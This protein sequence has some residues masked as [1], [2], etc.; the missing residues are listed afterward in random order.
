MLN[1]QFKKERTLMK[2]IFLVMF[3]LSSTLVFAQ[4]KVSGIVTDKSGEPLIGVNVLEKGTTN[5]C[6]TDID[7]KYSLNVEKNKI[8]VFSFIGYTK[9]EI[10]T[11]QSTINVTLVED[12]QALEEVVI[13]GY[14]S[15]TRKDVT[16][17]ITT[18]KADKLNQGVFS[19]PGQLLQGKVPGLTITQSSDPNSGT[20]SITLRGASTLRTGAAQE[21]Y[22]IIDGVPG[23]S[24]SLIS[25]DDIESI[26]VL[27]DATATAIYGSKAA[28]GVIIVTTKKGS[29]ED[30]TN[31]SYSGYMAIDNVMK[32]LDMMS[33]SELRAYA[34]KNNIVF[35]NDMGANTDWQKEV[36]RTAFSHN[37][38]VSINGGNEKTSYSASI[39][40]LE[41]QGAIRGTNMDRLTARSFLQTKTLQNRLTLSLSLNGSVTNK[42]TTPTG[43][44]GASVLDAMNYY[45]PLVPIRDDEGN[46]YEDTAISQNYNP[47]SLINENQYNSETKFL[48]GVAKASL[49][50]V[51]GLV[52]NLSLS[53]QNEQYVNNLYETSKSLVAKGMDG[54]SMRES[55]TN[56]K[57][58]L[59]TYLNYDKT[60]N[61]IHKLGLMAGYSWEEGNDNDGFKLTTYGYYNDDLS[62]HNMGMANFIDKNGI[63]GW[64]MSTLRMISFYA[65]V[66]YSLASKYLLQATI[67]RDGS[68]A[69]G[70]NNRWATFPSA[71]LAWRMSEESFIK[72]LNIFDDLKF[73]IG[74]GVSGNSLG[75]NAYSAIQT[76]GVTGWYDYI[77]PSGSSYPVHTLGAASNSNPDLKWERTGMFNIGL[78]FAFLNNRLSGTIEWYNKTT[79]DLIYD[80]AVSTNRYPFGSMTANVGE[81]NNKGI[82]ITINAVP[83]KT[84]NF[85][86]ETTL[87]LSHNKNEVVK[88]SNSAYSVKYINQGNA[89]INGISSGAIADTQRIMEGQPIGT[90]YMLEWAGVNEE[91]QSTWYKRN[92]ET[93]ERTGEVT[94]DPKDTDRTIVGNAQPKLTYGWNNTLTWKNWSLTAFIQGTVG[95]K[96]FNSTRAQYNSTSFVTLGKNV[97]REVANC[98]AR[99][100]T[101]NYPS[102]RYL[103][104]GSYLRLSTLSLGYNFGKIGNWLNNLR[105][106][107]TCNNLFTITGYKGTDPEVSLGGIAPG[108]DSRETYY[109]RTRTFMLGLNVNF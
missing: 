96:I 58:V 18:V 59:E 104:D 43:T 78:D 100:K 94:S 88:L 84:K 13:V 24:L 77:S 12:A 36:Q 103:E 30:H 67:R 6:I 41:K 65:R 3:M 92:P 4:N 28:N 49:N 50:I 72:N 52:Y 37:H 20:S 2:G 71:S 53:Y 14:G 81:I 17:S 38:N 23:M 16:S 46:W 93:G 61:D 108:I 27:R 66:N 63:G 109:P 15:M 45:S 51:D 79:K 87:N 69:F 106:Y 56:K 76:Y 40:Y 25:P 82:E 44:D 98:D 64:E 91:G 7:G 29:K 10:P 60:F 70:K 90:F 1:V 83:V 105:V 57:K 5:G 80:Y 19:D 68:S 32:N 74:Y 42:Y 39:N 97:L 26:D 75:F 55:V 47:L 89:N 34:Q 54:R 21:P 86:W 62:Y 22:Y 31:V 95:N 35:N 99:D 9:Q 33:A 8:L 11:T 101:A 85:S 73:R 102:D 107:A 48:Q